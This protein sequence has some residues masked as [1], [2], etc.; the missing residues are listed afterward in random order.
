MLDNRIISRSFALAGILMVAASIPG[1][2]GIA[3]SDWAEGHN[4][5]ARLIAGGAG[6]AGVELQLPEGWKTYWRSPGEAGGVP[7]SFDWSKSENLASAKVLY[8]APKRSTD[9]SG[10]SIGYKGTIVFPVRIEA[11]DPTQPIDLRLSFDYGVCKNICIPA[12]AE[13]ELKLSPDDGREM[14]EQMIEA[15]THLPSPPEA[16][17]EGDPILKRTEAE[18]AGE[19]PHLLIE[20]QFPDGG[21][22]ADIFLEGPDGLYVPSAKKLKDDGKGNITFEVDLSKDADID[23]LKGKQLTAT[24]VSEKGQSEVSFPLQ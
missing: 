23:L 22:H 17:R 7:P 10:D 18:L 20:A 11:K 12:Q 16:H 1:S 24:L 15:M 3:A 14:S 21:A 4:S 5:R 2:A 6:M 9:K 13:L 19:R 8:P